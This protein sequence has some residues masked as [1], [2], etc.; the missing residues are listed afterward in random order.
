MQANI[1]VCE[2]Y[3]VLKDAIALQNCEKITQELK[4][5]QTE[6]PEFR[7]SYDIIEM[8]FKFG[9]T[10]SLMAIINSGI[11]IS[12]GYRAGLCSCLF[13]ECSYMVPF[14]YPCRHSYEYSHGVHN[15][16]ACSMLSNDVVEILS[17]TERLSLM[18]YLLENKLIELLRP[19]DLLLAALL[20]RDRE[21]LDLCAQYNIEFSDH[22]INKTIIPLSRDIMN[23]LKDRNMYLEK[24]FDICEQLVHKLKGQR[25]VVSYDFVEQNPRLLKKPSLLERAVQ[26]FDF[27]KVNKFQ[28]MKSNFRIEL[29]PVYEKIGWLKQRTSRERLIQH[30]QDNNNTEITAW[31]LDFKYRT[32]DLGKERLAKER[33]ELMELNASPNSVYSLRKIW[34]YKKNSSGTGLIITSY[35]GPGTSLVDIPARI[36]RQ[37]VVEIGAHIFG[38]AWDKQIEEINIPEGVE[39]IHPYAFANSHT[40][41]TIRLPSSLKFI[42]RNV[43]SSMSSLIHLYIPAGV[44]ELPEQMLAYSN[45]EQL[46]VSLSE[47]LEV[48][49]EDA[50]FGTQIKELRI[51]ASVAKIEGDR[52]FDGVDT[53]VVKKGSYAEEYCAE[54]NAKLIK[55]SGFSNLYKYVVED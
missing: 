5:Q 29:M 24:F 35:K 15:W 33:R 50:F 46:E 23:I 16:Y 42:G 40:L 12:I 13:D 2:P 18:Q 41:K 28:V 19:E 31:L 52:T 20:Q 9:G 36:G 8:A 22:F 14:W 32:V 10:K 25:L 1:Q 7:V 47:G 21:V 55:Y 34:S 54:H 44:R 27:K 37:P 26:L 49:S 51:P 53:L 4:K 3:A 48:I 6:N 38:K 43:F 17:K 11:K 30:A 45:N 39:I